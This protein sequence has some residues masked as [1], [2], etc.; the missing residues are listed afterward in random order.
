[1]SSSPGPSEFGTMTV[2]PATTLAVETVRTTSECIVFEKPR[3]PYF[4]G[5]IMPKNF[6]SRMKRQTSGGR[7]RSCQA[8][9]Q[10][11]TIAQSWRTGPSMKACS[12]PL[13]FAGGI[14]RSAFQSGSPENSSP[15]HHTVPASI[16]SRSVSEIGG[17]TVPA[18]RKI[19]LVR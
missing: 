2:T 11:S 7:S 12:R 1:M 9:F 8:I 6:S 18:H 17:M 4:S 15:S 14:A 3:P 10:S 13:S 5:M 19:G 16:A